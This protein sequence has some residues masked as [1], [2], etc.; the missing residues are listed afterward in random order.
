MTTPPAD[1]LLAEFQHLRP[2]ADAEL[3]ALRRA[4]VIEDVLGVR[5]TDAQLLQPPTDPALL[6]D[7][8]AVKPS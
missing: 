2:V 1:R 3:D 5:L 8:T 7:L 6:R 4:L